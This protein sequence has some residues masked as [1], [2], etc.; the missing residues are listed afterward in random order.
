MS[1]IVHVFDFYSAAISSIERRNV[2]KVGYSIDRRSFGQVMQCYNDEKVRSL[3]CF[4]CAQV[5]PD[6][7]VEHSRIKIRKG[8]WIANLSTTALR[9]NLLYKQFRKNYCMTPRSSQQLERHG[10]TP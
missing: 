10:T 8:G 3:I 1:S 7:G 4:V 2:P 5:K 9:D 6:T